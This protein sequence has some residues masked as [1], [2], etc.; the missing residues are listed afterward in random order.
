[1]KVKEFIKELIL[2]FFWLIFMVAFSTG[3]K[4]APIKKHEVKKEERVSNS[5]VSG[6]IIPDKNLNTRF[7]KV[8]LAVNN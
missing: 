2:P 1:M 6:Y 3:S 8:N 7:I 5:T 4:N